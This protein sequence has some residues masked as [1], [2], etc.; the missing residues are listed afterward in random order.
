MFFAYPDY[1]SDEYK[2]HKLQILYNMIED[3]VKLADNEEI[4]IIEDEG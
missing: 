2:V 4:V 3:N 1:T